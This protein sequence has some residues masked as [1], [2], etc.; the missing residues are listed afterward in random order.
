[1]TTDYLH[2]VILAVPPVQLGDFEGSGGELGGQTG[3]R[4]TSVDADNDKAGQSLE[5]LSHLWPHLKMTR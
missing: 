4:L 5:S 3:A 2:L 1:M